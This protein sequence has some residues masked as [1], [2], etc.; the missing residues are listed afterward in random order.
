MVYKSTSRSVIFFHA[1]KGAAHTLPGV[2]YS[3]NF[4]QSTVHHQ[5]CRKIPHHHLAPTDYLH[6]NTIDM[7]NYARQFELAIKKAWITGDGYWRCFQ[8]VLGIEVC[9]A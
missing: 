3:A 6:N 5:Y 7:H 2:P 8:T 4:I 1:S 9:D